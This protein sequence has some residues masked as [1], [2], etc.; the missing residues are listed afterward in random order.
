M[1]C[2]VFISLQLP[3]HVQFGM[4]VENHFWDIESHGIYSNIAIM[5]QV[6]NADGD[7]AYHHLLCQLV[8]NPSL[9]YSLERV[10][11]QFDEC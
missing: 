2:D 8:Y 11:H 9:A 6:N 1:R 3:V 7:E 10:I 5:K 4:Y